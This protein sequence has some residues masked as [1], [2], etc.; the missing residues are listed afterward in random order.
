MLASAWLAEVTGRPA[1]FTAAET[2]WD[3]LFNGA[4]TSW[5]SQIP[6]WDNQWWAGNVIL[7]GLTGRQRYQ[8]SAAQHTTVIRLTSEEAT[9]HPSLMH[10]SLS[11]LF[12]APAPAVLR[13][14]TRGG[15]S[16]QEGRGERMPAF[17]VSDIRCQSG[18][19]CPQD[20][21]QAFFTAWTQGSASVA[22]TPQGLARAGG[23]GQLR[24]AANAALLAM[25]HA[26][27][28]TGFDGVRLACWARSQVLDMCRAL[29]CRPCSHGSIA[30]LH[31][32]RGH[33]V[34][35]LR[36]H[37]SA[38]MS[39]E[40]TRQRWDSLSDAVQR[41]IADLRCSTSW[42]QGGAATWSGGESARPAM[43]PARRPPARQRCSPVQHQ[44]PP[45]SSMLP[46]TPTLTPSQEP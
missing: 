5:Q 43:C 37:A 27:H 12:I 28:S 35:S 41:D 22:Y 31:K 7:L 6:N 15:S 44:K 14:R 36:Q 1:Y 16:L 19:S 8:V 18:E 42:A 2:Y 32:H 17:P 4:S 10:M 40:L 33:L 23:E 13:I 3:R 26:R 30:C 39:P 25:V 29:L 46:R 45:A 21:V 24:S 38:S 20:Q 34:A 9:L 11:H